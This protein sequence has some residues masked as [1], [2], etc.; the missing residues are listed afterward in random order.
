MKGDKQLALRERVLEEDVWAVNE[1]ANIM[2]DKVAECIRRVGK[3]VLGES[4]GGAPAQKE[5]WWWS[6]AVQEKIR[7][8][9]ECFKT[10]QKD[11]NGVNLE[12][13]KEAKKETKKAVSEAKAKAFEEL[14]RRLDTKESEREIF[15]L[16]KARDRRTKDLNQVKCIK[17]E[18]EKVLVKEEEIKERWKS[19]F[20]K[21]FNESSSSDVQ[22]GQITISRE[23]SK[24]IFL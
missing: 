11:Q 19:Y 2:W 10:W 3:E 6:E 24:H 9:R 8:K 5:A 4:K 18:D 14:Y 22:L 7:V 13:Y 17:D 15:K 16:A 1:S 23:E 12:R 20:Y 21:L